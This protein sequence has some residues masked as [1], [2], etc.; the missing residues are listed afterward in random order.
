VSTLAIVTSQVVDHAV[1]E[2]VH[3][4]V[5]NPAENF[6]TVR[7]A[8]PGEFDPVWPVRPG[9]GAAAEVVEVRFFV[10]IDNRATWIPWGKFATTGGHRFNRAGDHQ[11]ESLMR[12]E[13]PD[14]AKWVKAEIETK[15]NIRVQLDADFE[16]RPRDPTAPGHHSVSVAAGGRKN[17]GNNIS[18]I[19]TAS[20]TP[21][22]SN[23]YMAA[24]AH[25]NEYTA[26]PAIT[27][28][29]FGSTAL[30]S[31]D[32]STYGSYGDTWSY[33]LVDPA[34]SSNDV[35]VT[36]DTAVDDLFVSALVF[37]GVNQTTPHG[38]IVES[39][40][41]GTN[42]EI[43]ISTRTGDMTLDFLAVED[44]TDVTEDGDATLQIQRTEGFSSELASTGTHATS[45]THSYNHT[46]RPY[47]IIGWNV[48]QHFEASH[49]E[50]G[51]PAATF[52]NALTLDKTMTA[53]ATA[54]AA[55]AAVA[56]AVAA[57]SAQ[58]IADAYDNLWL[59]S[60]ALATSP[61]VVLGTSVVVPD[62]VL[63][64]D[65][66]TTADK[67]SGA[68]VT[69]HGRR[70]QINLLQ[71]STVYNV[72]QFVRSDDTGKTLL[73]AWQ[74]SPISAWLGWAR[75]DWSG[76][77]PVIDPS[78]FGASDIV[79]QRD[80]N[81]FWRLSFDLTSHATEPDSGFRCHDDTLVL[82]NA[83][84]FWGAQVTLGAGVK[85]YRKTTTATDSGV[86]LPG[87][88]ASVVASISAAAT[89]SEA[90]AAIASFVAALTAGGTASEVMTAVAT[91][92]TSIS[93]GASAAELQAA[94]A[95]VAESIS[96]AASATELQAATA[97]VAGSISAAGSSSEAFVGVTQLNAAISAGVTA[98]ELFA[99]SLAA[100]AGFSAAGTASEGD[101]A[102]AAAVAALVE[103][104]TG[105][106]TL[107]AV[108]SVVESILEGA[109]SG[110]AI[111]GVK[112]LFGDVA[113]DGTPDDFFSAVSSVA[114]VI[115]EAATSSSSE[116]AVATALA[117]M[118][119][120]GA[121]GESIQA[122]HIGRLMADAISGDSFGH[123]AMIADAILEGASSAA[124][125][126]SAFATSDAFSASATAG[127]LFRS[128]VPGEMIGSFI[129]GA[130]LTTDIVVN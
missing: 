62:D 102:L 9:S 100:A 88:A 53:A 110:E 63:A 81:G 55:L 75:I 1:K 114:A 80:E 129:I 79:L 29:E 64:P 124:L 18:T 31:R 91:L 87:A 14:G 36:L 54:S 125:F 38:S 74:G 73:G 95:S 72:S 121:P 93:A 112:K 97:S 22:G 48:I 13:L 106:A 45:V 70:Q 103:S 46:S 44:T 111:S 21:G 115:A 60:E 82:G 3:R 113:I 127:S 89:A 33:Y 12:L 5:P 57:I 41:S 117:A 85:P 51:A 84:W 69:W 122:A 56:D 109:T 107:D 8:R 58:A 17:S 71:P 130:A 25:S 67:M 108:A 65:G 35:T 43:S 20:F 76:A 7:L 83:A 90:Q 123:V 4:R 116:G 52:A 128:P 6:M 34:A 101:T 16:I 68:T 42:S 77:D 119:S 94:V 28:F 11:L 99:Y 49:S 126:G 104:G 39:A 50:D 24:H 47:H 92:L 23:R 32:V 26:N 40:T 96:E 37:A 105:N 120:D 98:T 10:S 27:V 15:E 86:M 2:S 61:W 118:S 59:Q 78:S 30:T 66:T 19:S